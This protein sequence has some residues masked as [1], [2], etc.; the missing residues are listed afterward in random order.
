MDHSSAI[1]DYVSKFL[2]QLLADELPEVQ[3]QLDT[4]SNV[5]QILLS[6]AHPAILIG[7][8]GETLSAL[9][10]FLS[11]HL[12]Q[13]LGEKVTIS[14]NVNDYREIGRASCRERV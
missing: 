7:Y 6:T 9:Q 2:S 10:L 4:E 8:H 11:M 12:N 1:S 13:V 5:Y 14:V 3:T